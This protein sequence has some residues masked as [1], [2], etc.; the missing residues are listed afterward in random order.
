MC[1]PSRRRVFVEKIVFSIPESSPITLPREVSRSGVTPT[2]Y[3]ILR[4]ITSSS[5]MPT[6][7]ISGTA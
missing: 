6:V 7:D 3:G 4:A 2:S 1:T 5:V